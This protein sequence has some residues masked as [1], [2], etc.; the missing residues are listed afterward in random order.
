MNYG[1]LN[2]QWGAE[3]LC[4][5]RPPK[6]HTMPESALPNDITIRI[7]RALTLVLFEI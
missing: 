4:R 3:H 2:K 1:I 5:G 7:T 6:D